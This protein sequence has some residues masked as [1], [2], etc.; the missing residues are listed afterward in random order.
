MTGCIRPKS[1]IGPARGVIPGAVVQYAQSDPR[2]PHDVSWSG[3][4]LLVNAEGA[5]HHTGQ[6]IDPSR[7]LIVIAADFQLTAGAAN[8]C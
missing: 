2:G 1:G 5:T 4:C 8:V 6:S 7:I 3:R